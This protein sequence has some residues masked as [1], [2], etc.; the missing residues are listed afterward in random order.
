MTIETITE[1]IFALAD[2]ALAAGVKTKD[3]ELLRAACALMFCGVQIT[4]RET[5]GEDAELTDLMGAA[6]DAVRDARRA[7]ERNSNEH[8]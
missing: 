6:H 3:E 4:D 7:R 8:N 2:R 5:G 1:T